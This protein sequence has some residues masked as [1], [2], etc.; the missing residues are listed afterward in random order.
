MCPWHWAIPPG[1]F[2]ALGRA[3]CQESCAPCPAL[4]P[5]AGMLPSFLRAR[6]GKGRGQEPAW[7]RLQ[8]LLPGQRGK[9]SLFFGSTVGQAIC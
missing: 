7:R 8:G 3:L 2:S 6:Q 9:V 4:S 5:E 1:C